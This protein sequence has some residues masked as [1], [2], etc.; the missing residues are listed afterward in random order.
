M[1]KE[2]DK[3]NVDK[4]E[5]VSRFKN[6]SEK[7]LTQIKK[8]KKDKKSLE[9]QVQQ[10]I[11]KEASNVGIQVDDKTTN[12]DSVNVTTQEEDEQVEENTHLDVAVQTM[13]IPSEC[14]ITNST[15]SSPEEN[16]KIGTCPVRKNQTKKVPYRHPNHENRRIN[17][18]TYLNQSEPKQQ[19]NVPKKSNV[20]STQCYED[21]SLQSFSDQNA[22]QKISLGWSDPFSVRQFCLS[23]RRS[24]QLV[25]TKMTVPREKDF[26]SRKRD[27]AFFHRQALR[28]KLFEEGGNVT[29]KI[30]K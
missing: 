23:L 20:T 30:Y 16:I 28:T 8:L 14:F 11:K 12:I 22:I 6:H 5:E 27:Q 2:I 10:L 17:H 24:Y 7:L 19:T 18:A 29:N 21:K 26:Q 25:S 1:Q 3:I 4:N 9:G 13:N 15:T